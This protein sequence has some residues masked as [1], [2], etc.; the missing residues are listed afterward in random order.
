LELSNASAAVCV[1]AK[2][3]TQIQQ[4]SKKALAYAARRRTR[5]G[6]S[7]SDLPSL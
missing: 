4:I 5:L 6:K 1:I 7:F 2:K 3:E